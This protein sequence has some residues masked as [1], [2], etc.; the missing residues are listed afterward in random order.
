MYRG[1]TER[2]YRQLEYQLGHHHHSDI[3]RYLL[4]W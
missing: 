2:N 4:G 3:V 1:K